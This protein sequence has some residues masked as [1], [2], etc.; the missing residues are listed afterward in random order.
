MDNN[1]KLKHDLEHETD[2][3]GEELLNEYYGQDNDDKHYMG[4]GVYGQT[5][6]DCCC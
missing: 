2:V 5:S 6:G 3:S 4:Y 1:E